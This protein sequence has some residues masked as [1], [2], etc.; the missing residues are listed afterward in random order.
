M[1]CG[2]PSVWRALI[3]AG[4][5]LLLGCSSLLSLDELEKVDC[6]AAACGGTAPTGGKAGEGGSG[7]TP[8]AQAGSGATAGAGAGGA[9]HLAGS[10]SGGEGDGGNA[11]TGS[12]AGTGGSAG[13]G[14]TAGSGGA[15]G[16]GPACEPAAVDVSCD[17][18]DAGC[19]PTD[20]DAACSGACQGAFLHGSS[21][22]ACYGAYDF[23]EAGAACDA[24][25]MRLIRV[26]SAAENAIVFDL[27]PDQYLWLGG[28]NRAD[29]DVFTWADDTPFYSFAEGS[30]AY[31]NFGEGQPVQHEDWR[32]VQFRQ[33]GD[34][35]WSNWR[36]TDA[37]SIVCE[38]Y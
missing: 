16:G 38:R 14:G 15:A 7:A 23:D 6:I 5:T 37:Q 10:G 9:T 22:M 8:N 35:V 29:Q 21:Y 26:D 28:S 32:C 18:L 31:D 19:E 25:G 17:G 36:C 4:S 33:V 34:G 1:R 11:G 3:S 2:A 27:A 20:D 24:N 30:S 12:S 13:S